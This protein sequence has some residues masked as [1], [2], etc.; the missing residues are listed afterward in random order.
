M[1][2]GNT[3]AATHGWSGS[4]TYKSWLAMRQRCNKPGVTSYEDYGGRG[5]RVCERWESFENFLADMGPRPVGTTLD[6]YPNGDGN[7]EPGNVRWATSAEQARNKRNNVRVAIAGSTALL[8]EVAERSGVSAATLRARVNAG[9]T[10]E[11]LTSPALGAE[12]QRR[13]AIDARIAANAARVRATHDSQEPCKWWCK[14]CTPEQ[15]K[16]TRRAEWAS[17]RE[18]VERARRAVESIPD[19]KAP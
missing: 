8:V 16:A 18:A 9:V 10:G 13:I 5:I 7:Y 19:R 12:A 2:E 1:R 11:A 17:T 4:G 6:R 14:F 3:Y 15:Q